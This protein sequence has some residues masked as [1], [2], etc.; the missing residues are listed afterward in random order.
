MRSRNIWARTVPASQTFCSA[1][2]WTNPPK[3]WTGKSK[4][5]S[6]TL[7][8][9]LSHWLRRQRSSKRSGKSTMNTSVNIG[10]TQDVRLRGA[11]L[12][13]GKSSYDAVPYRHPFLVVHEVVHDDDGAR[14]AE[15]Q[16]VTPQV[17]IDLM[18]GLG[19]SVPIEILPERV[20]VRTSNIIIWWIPARERIMFFS[21]RSD[22]A[23]LKKMNGKR[24]PHP[25][26]L[27]KTSGTHLAVRALLENR[28]P[29]SDSKL[30]MAPYWNCYQN[31]VVCTGTMKMPREKSVAA[32]ETWEESFFQSEFTH[33][34]GVRN[35]VRYP[36]GFLTM[37]KFLEG[38]KNFR[39]RYLVSAKQPLLDFMSTDIYVNLNQTNE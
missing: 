15:G 14:L 7:L 18:V 9:C 31:G 5:Y 10:S 13:Y 24:Y 16:L 22:D 39:S 38:K 4:K 27:F 11:L 12:V 37:W 6:A 1:S 32:T 19:Q 17:L 3:N 23:V 30:Y 36:G 35:H 34:A 26:L 2:I 25:P 20:I 8:R 28:R 33:G 29:K 21:D